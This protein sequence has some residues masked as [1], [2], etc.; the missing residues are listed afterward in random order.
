MEAM[1]TGVQVLNRRALERIPEGRHWDSAE[2]LYPVLMREGASLYGYIMGGEWID[3]GTPKR[4]LEAN[5]LAMNSLFFTA[6]GERED[7]GVRERPGVH[8]AVMSEVGWKPPILLGE[9][10]ML[11]EGSVVGPNLVMGDGCRV[12]RGARIDNCVVWEGVEIGRDSSLKG[13]ILTGGVNIPPRSV[14]EESMVVR[15]RDGVL[16]FHPI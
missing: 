16:S 1:F 3:M 5:F 2:E 10:C 12:G 4:Y 7:T 15:D 11:E 6:A 14:I 8:P 13:S 9:G